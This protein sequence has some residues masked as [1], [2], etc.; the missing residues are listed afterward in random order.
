MRRSLLH[1]M[2]RVFVPVGLLEQAMHVLAGHPRE[3]FVEV[4]VVPRWGAMVFDSRA[5][6]AVVTEEVK[7]RRQLR[8][9][10][11]DAST[12]AATEVDVDQRQGTEFFDISGGFDEDAAEPYNEDPDE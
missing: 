12:T 10:L 9:Q 11:S 4:H 7:P 8:A 1:T 3:E 2:V 6:E 5:D